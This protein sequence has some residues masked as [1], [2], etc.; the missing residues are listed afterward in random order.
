LALVALAC[1][2]PTLGCSP[3]VN[4]HDRLQSIVRA[5]V[6]KRSVHYVGVWTW[7]EGRA[8]VVGDVGIDRGMTRITY[9]V[10]GKTGHLA[11]VVAARTLYLRGDA[12]GLRTGLSFSPSVAARYAGKWI[13]YPPNRYDAQPLAKMDILGGLVSYLEPKGTSFAATPDASDHGR[14]VIVLR[15]TVGP[16][17]APTRTTTLYAQA[18][19]PPLP[20]KEV[21]TGSQP[22]SITLSRWGE[23]VPVTA[24]VHS[25]AAPPQH[26]SYAQIE[27]W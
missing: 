23:T 26:L 18:D 25:V 27:R 10:R 20:V 22:F 12:A 4:A 16:A 9:L 3:T 7:P 5:A 11:E 24:P 13:A 6:A 8:A 21:Q 2:L 15:N 1:S 17:T 14:P 19:G